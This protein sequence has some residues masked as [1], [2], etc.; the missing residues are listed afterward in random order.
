M[1][2]I[3]VAALLVVAAIA[4]GAGASADTTAAVATFAGSG[5][6]L[7]GGLLLVRVLPP[8][9]RR[10]TIATKG[11]AWA[12]AGIGLAVGLGCV[13]GSGLV[14]AGGAELDPGARRA[15]DDLDISIG[16][17]WWQMAL[18][19]CAL[20][21]FAPLGEE[22]LF[23]GLALRGLVRLMPFAWAA[24][25]SGVVFTAAHFDAYLVWPRAVAL[26]LVGWVLAWIYRRRGLL[27][28]VAAHATVNAIAFDREHLAV[29]VNVSA[30]DRLVLYNRSSTEQWLAS[31][32]KYHVSD[33]SLNHGLLA[34]SVRDHL[35]PTTP[36]TKYMDREI[37]FMELATNTTHVLTS[38]TNDQWGPQVLENH[39]V[40]F[41]LENDVRTIEV[42][43]W[44][45]ELRPY[46]SFI[47][48]AGVL[49]AFVVVAWHMW[50]R[51]SERRSS[52]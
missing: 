34:W 4:D 36:Q 2:A 39:L 40:Y 23:R 11:R 37:Y 52:L 29:T 48:Q 46:S 22:L 13:V 49:L 24:P 41:Q 5:V 50:Q 38:D 28:S 10:V 25:V 7:I 45:P 33:P 20:V 42:H 1:V 21:I 3:G 43:S 27:G 31:N 16:A 26:V 15:L 35:N 32:P 14:I 51:Q 6:I 9:Q 44:E 12:T 47:L 30:T 8:A 18:T 17:A 19:A